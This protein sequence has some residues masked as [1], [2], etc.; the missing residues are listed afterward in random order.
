MSACTA[1][2]FTDVTS[3]QFAPLQTKAQASGIPLDGNSGSGSSFGSKFEWNYDPTTPAFTIAPSS[4]ANSAALPPTSIRI[5][6][7]PRY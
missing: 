4:H 7:S 6:G 1:Q 3:R 5:A 2:R